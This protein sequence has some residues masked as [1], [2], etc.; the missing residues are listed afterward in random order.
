[1]NI[2]LFQQLLFHPFIAKEGKNLLFAFS[3]R[4]RRKS[5]PYTYCNRKNWQESSAH[6]LTITMIDARQTMAFNFSACWGAISN[7]YVAIDIKLN[8]QR[9]KDISASRLSLSPILII[10]SQLQLYQAGTSQFPAQHTSEYEV[11]LPF[12]QFEI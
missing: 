2:A 1:M 6:K 4:A 12:S 11:L 10:V 8:G 5:Q 7:A 9:T 3:I